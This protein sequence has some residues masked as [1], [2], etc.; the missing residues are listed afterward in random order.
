MASSKVTK[1]LLSLILLGTL[2][3]GALPKNVMAQNCGCRPGLCCSEFGFC[4]NGDPY[5][6]KGCREGPC[7]GTPTTPGQNNGGGAIAD[8]VTPQFFSGI[9][10]K[11]TGNCPGKS[12]YNRNAFINAAKSYSQFGSGSADASK[13]EIAAFFAHISHETGCK[14]FSLFLPLLPSFVVTAIML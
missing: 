4:G 13:R 9:I 5:C 8:I 12:F 3:A 2:L 14:I 1:T 10:N 11:A 6:G 7:F